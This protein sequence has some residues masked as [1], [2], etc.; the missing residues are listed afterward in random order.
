MSSTHSN[1]LVRAIGRWTLTA[2]VINVVIASGIFRLPQEVASY[3]GPRAPWAY[4]IAAAGIGVIMACFA[5][6]AS[7]F[8]EAGGPYLYA[9]TAFGRLAGIQMGWLA[10]VVRITSGAANANVFVIY[11]G[12]FWPQAT[13]PLPRA[14]ILTLLMGFLVAVNYF[15]VKSGAKLSNLLTAAKLVSL[16]AFIA[17]GLALLRGPMPA[18]APPGSGNWMAAIL[19]LIFAYGG[20]EAALMGMSEVKD[21]RRDAPFALFA[22][23]IAATVVY[24]LVHVVVMH[25][26]ANPAAAERPLAAAAQVFLGTAGAAL[27]SVGAMLSTYGQ[28]SGQM[29]VAPRLTFA[30]AQGGDFPAFFAAVHPK[31]RTPHVSIVIFGGLMLALAI[32]GSFIWN[33]ILS[34]V[35]RLFTYGLVC[36]AL[37]VLRRRNP[38][39]DAFRLPGGPLLAVAGITFCLLLIAQMN[40]QHLVILLV[41]FAVALANWWIVRSRR[42][43]A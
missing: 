36:G 21:P 10:W 25:A 37:I 38:Q 14:G 43:A 3:L 29:V 7:Q 32:Y 8:R 12:Q 18:D 17:L 6:V 5:E 9:R 16:L 1:T 20:F 22:G 30:F 41:V 26:L 33:A 19:A 35:A 13:Q 40:R 42:P 31:F 15:G 28:L 11:L 27:I 23:L 4:L 39:A 34:A 2:L 24:T